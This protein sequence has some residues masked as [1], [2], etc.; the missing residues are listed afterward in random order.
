MVAS[1]CGGNAVV[2]I[3][4]RQKFTRYSFSLV[5]QRITAPWQPKAFP[6]VTKRAKTSFS[7][8]NFFPLPPCADRGRNFFG[9]RE[10]ERERG[11]GGERETERRERG[12]KRLRRERVEPFFLSGQIPL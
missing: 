2:Y 7:I 10:R 1:E 9:L 12:G 6:K 5:L 8:F 4:L 11:R 3:K